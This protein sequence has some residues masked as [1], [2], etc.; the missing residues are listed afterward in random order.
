MLLFYSYERITDHTATLI[1][2]IYTNSLSQIISTGIL[3]NDISDHFGTYINLKF[4][5]NCI[6]TRPNTHELSINIPH[7]KL[8]AANIKYFQRLISNESW[9]TTTQQ[10]TAQDKF[11]KFIETYTKHYDTAFPETNNAIKRKHQRRN[12]K[13]WILPWL[14]DACA[15]KNK[16]YQDFINTPSIEN[17]IKYYK[18]KNLSKST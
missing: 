18:M 12:P 7:R 1:D 16:L 3:I 9:D 8:T 2:H 10:H 5:S 4:N 13:P 15:R 6:N 11:N 17:K 14:E